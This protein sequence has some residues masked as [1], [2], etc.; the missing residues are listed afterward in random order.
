MAFLTGEDRLAR[1]AEEAAIEECSCELSSWKNL[2][3]SS[4]WGVMKRDGI[5]KRESK[6]EDIGLGISIC[7]VNE[8]EK[9]GC[10]EK[11]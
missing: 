1:A 5:W 8:R 3:I 4:C 7:R 6:D 2:V 10:F 9:E 11:E